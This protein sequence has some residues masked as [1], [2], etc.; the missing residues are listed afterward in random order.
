[1]QIYRIRNGNKF[2]SVFVHV[3]V[4]PKKFDERVSILMSRQ[5]Y[6]FKIL[7]EK[8]PICLNDYLQASTC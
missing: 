1:M 8:R 6:V 4:V 5:Y 3:I 2:R 7:D